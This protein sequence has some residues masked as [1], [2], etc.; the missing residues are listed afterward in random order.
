MRIILHYTI[1]TS[2]PFCQ[3]ALDL[4]MNLDSNTVVFDETLKQR[5][6]QITQALCRVTKANISP[7]FYAYL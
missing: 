5:I 2:L 4:D 6:K 7:P 1:A 3:D